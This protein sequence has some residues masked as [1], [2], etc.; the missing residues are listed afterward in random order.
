[1][2]GDG[3][4]IA[5]HLPGHTPD[6]LALLVNLPDGPV[7]LSGDVYHSQMAREKRGVPPFNTSRDQ[8]L[9]S[10]DRFEAI[11]KETGAKVVIQ[12][13]PAD[14]TKLPAVAPVAE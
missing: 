6:H 1:M 3:K 13:E 12:H 10:M 14:I 5:L 9:E 4:V 7:L 11:A 8:T 2:F